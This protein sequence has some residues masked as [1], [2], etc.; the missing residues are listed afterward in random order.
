MR[1]KKLVV[2]SLDALIAEDLAYLKTKPT[3]SML[4]EGGARVERLKSVYPS[5]TYV[6]HTTMATGCYPDKHGVVNNTAVTFEVDPPWLFGH[7]NVKVKDILDA[8]KAAGLTTASVGWP[9]SGCHASVDYLV[10]ECWPSK[11]APIE[12]YKRVY[13]ENG[14]SPTLFDEVVSPILWM[15]VGRKQP[16]SSY[17]LTKI[18]AEIIRR[19]QPDLLML[20][21]GNID[22]CRHRSGVYSEHVKKALDE[23]E[24]MVS[25][26]IGATQ[27][28]DVFEDTDFI[29]TADHGQLDAVRELRL[30]TRFV[31]ES[32]I[33]AD[34]TGRVKKA[35]A[36]CQPSG[37]SAEIYLHEPKNKALWE[38][39]YAVLCE[40]RDERIGI[41]EVYT[42]K[43]FQAM[44]LDG[45]FSFI[46]EGDEETTFEADLFGPTVIDF[47]GG[48]HGFHP[49]KGPRPPFIA[50]GPSIK[51]G[52]VLSAGHL[53]D[54]APTYAKI[55][56]V[57]LPDADGLPF[58]DL[59][60]GEHK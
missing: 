40:M 30:N 2:I 10:N 47:R 26:I 15:R 56:G 24:E 48:D 37:M 52:V 50:Y 12:E 5:L 29:I 34:E 31:K 3:F 57:E 39:V 7:E 23:C 19:Y 59:L 6:C 14:T 27:D 60:K 25:M 43:E 13:L 4:L 32:L 11:G 42:K 51:Q 16:E 22:S 38:K 8:A 28:A 33:E 17:F 53:V 18:S 44:H 9:V 45:D 46:V 54:G 41:A 1:R 55:L 35:L 49:D 58:S 20:H 21:Q 36:W